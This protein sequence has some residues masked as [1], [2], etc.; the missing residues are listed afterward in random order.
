MKAKVLKPWNGA[1]AFEE[2]NDLESDV[3]GAKKMDHHDDSDHE[4]TGSWSANLEAIYKRNQDHCHDHPTPITREQHIIEIGSIRGSNQNQLRGV[5][6]TREQDSF[7]EDGIV[8]NSPSHS[9]DDSRYVGD[10]DDE[11]DRN[12]YQ[13]MG[14]NNNY[15][16]GQYDHRFDFRKMV[17]R[18]TGNKFRSGYQ[19]RNGKKRIHHPAEVGKTNRIAVFGSR[20][21]KSFH[22]LP[23]II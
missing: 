23:S 1:A 17:R 19:Y 7:I 13:I 8:R 5:W 21:K 14:G 6:K 22:R 18:F 4:A 9:G 15:Q 10:L 3:I 11:A 16:Y 12:T 20:S 2:D